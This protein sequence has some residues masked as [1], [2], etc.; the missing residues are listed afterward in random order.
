MIGSPALAR[1]RGCYVDCPSLLGYL[2]GVGAFVI[3]D[4]IIYM[5]YTNPPTWREV[6][7]E[8]GP[9]LIFVAAAIGSALLGAW[10][11]AE[12]WNG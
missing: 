5:F 8:P 11:S 4:G 7:R 1:G 6:K 9:I 12:M 2:I 3:T 10:L